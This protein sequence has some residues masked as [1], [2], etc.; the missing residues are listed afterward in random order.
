MVDPDLD[1]R[2]LVMVQNNENYPVKLKK[3]SV[4]G[5]VVTVREVEQVDA[6]DDVADDMAHCV[7]SIQTA[8]SVQPMER[9]KQLL[10]ALHINRESITKE[11]VTQLEALVQEYTDVFAVDPSDL[12]TTDKITHG[13]ETG[14]QRPPPRRVPFALRDQVNK[15]VQDMLDRGIIEPSKSPWRVPSFWWRRKMELS[16]FALTTVD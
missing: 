2:V 6:E 13:I 5:T 4:L 3:G 10:K 7:A 1:H 16:A 9:E 8:V 14:D 15:M 11:E 12:G